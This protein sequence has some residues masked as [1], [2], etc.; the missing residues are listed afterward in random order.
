MKCE[1]V[2]EK[3]ICMRKVRFKIIDIVCQIDENSTFWVCDK[4]IKYFI[5]ENKNNPH[6]ILLEESSDKE[7]SK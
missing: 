4:C 2:S 3:N 5:F 6:Y 1:A 7:K